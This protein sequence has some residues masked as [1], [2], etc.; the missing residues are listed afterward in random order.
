MKQKNEPLT[1]ATQ[2]SL[3]VGIVLSIAE[4]GLLTE[5]T[6]RLKGVTRGLTALAAAEGEGEI[7]EWVKS[8][9]R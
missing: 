1:K 8:V 2:D 9:M 3:L 7:V 6:L 5:K 4:Q